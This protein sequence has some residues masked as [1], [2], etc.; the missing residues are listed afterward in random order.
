MKKIKTATTMLFTMM[1]LLFIPAITVSA[2]SLG[3]TVSQNTVKDLQ[4]I[5]Y[6]NNETIGSLLAPSRY[7]SSDKLN[8]KTE[9]A[10]REGKSPAD[11]TDEQAIREL[12]QDN[13]KVVSF[14]ESFAEVQAEIGDVIQRVVDSTSGAENKGAAF[15]TN[16]ILQNKEQLL[17]GLTYLQRL[18]DFNMGE[19]NLKDAL[20]YESKPFLYGKV[21]DVLDWLIYIGN[22]G[23][24][25]LKISNNAKVFGLNKIFWPVTFTETL[26][27]FLEEH[28][29]KWIPDTSMNEWFLQES[30]AY[31]VENSSSWNSNDSGLY[32]RLYDEATFRAHILPL[33]TVSEDSVYMIANSATITYGIVDCYIDR[34]LK[35]T[36]P[37]RYGELRKEFQQQLAQAAKQQTA[38]IDF[39]YRIAKP[40][41]KCLLS[42]NRIVLDSLRIDPDTTVQWSD[43]F[44]KNASLGVREFF[45]P[46]NLYGNYMF[47]D[48]VAEGN[49]IRYYVSKAL[50]E[51]GFATYA[52][53]L[54]HIL[55]PDV[56][57]NGHGSRDG[58][59]AEVYTRGMFEPYELNDPPAFNLNL[60]YD[61]QADSDR[62]HNALPERFQDETD[63]QN[64]MSGILDVIYTLDYAEADVLFSKSAEEKMKWFHKLEQ[65]EDPDERFNQGEEGSIHN[66]DSVR[67]LTLD[68]AK[69]LNTIDDLIQ[70]NIIASRS[71]IDG[72]I[73]TGTMARNGYYV[74]PLF[75]ANY[76]AV[77]NNYGV[78]GDLTIR[79]QAFELLAEY[80]YYDGMVPYISNQYKESAKSDQTILSDQYILNKIFGNAYETMAD[81]KKA[82][83]QRRIEKINELKPITIMWKNQSVSIKNYEEL[84]LLMKEAIESDLINVNA[85]PNGSNNI[86]AHA[87]EVEH[88]KQEIFKAYLIQTED[89]S[90]SIYGTE[91]ENPDPP[92]QPDTPVQPNTPEN[93]DENE[94]PGQP[95]KPGDNEQPGQPDKP[96][97]NDTQKPG[98]NDNQQSDSNNTQKPDTG[99]STQDTTPT[100]LLCKVSAA[101]TSQTIRWTSVESA[102]GYEI[103]GAKSNGKYKLLRTVRKT[104]M[105]WTHKKLKKGTQ[106]KYYVKAFKIID[107]KQVSLAKSLSV[108]SITK[109]GKYSNPSKIKV[110]KTRLSVKTGKNI[111]LRVKITGKKMNKTGK[112]VRYVS[113]NP[114]VAKAS[115]KGV[116]TGKKHGSCTI[117]CIAQNG[118]YKKVIVKVVK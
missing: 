110:T 114:S 42:S 8:K 98:G 62:Y 76:A 47:A 37:A 100:Q 77:Q 50:T 79:R 94:Q 45:T 32:R 55:V 54:T 95:D 78:S 83:F 117:Y 53:E 22:S 48:G 39:W 82:M 64:Y 6:G 46:L 67:K 116:I 26:D 93:P 75:S 17:L 30:S 70:N 35:E 108:Y 9:I 112:K 24:D 97:D 12:N 73:T 104:S 90:K 92:N 106:Y 58:M 28:R 19:H 1:T 115:N 10:K 109:G 57:L 34:N 5:D 20:L 65:T 105:K 27:D 89:F 11:I 71:E 61:R 13:L 15:Y 25:T 74:V 43:K 88:L 63:L 41:K 33:L 118:L 16:K 69:N 23:G 7:S 91:P 21:E 86:R 2:A 4:A 60:I 14:E 111:Q 87:T 31:I 3:E 113:S 84:N 68:E 52:H 72:T 81:F 49:G 102:D 80:G 99:T 40:E 36:D 56:M 103:Y 96:G 107:G 18:Y 85:L 51:R 59:M 29:Q 44:G 66:L 101:K 38:F